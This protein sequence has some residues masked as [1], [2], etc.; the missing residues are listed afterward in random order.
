MRK[1]DYDLYFEHI[2][3]EPTH[4]EAK[5]ELELILDKEKRDGKR[6]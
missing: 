4:V 3:I 6:E 2:V 5:K 1:A